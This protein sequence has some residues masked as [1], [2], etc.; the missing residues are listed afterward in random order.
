MI[1]VRLIKVCLN[2]TYDK[3]LKVH[4]GHQIPLCRPWLRRIFGHKV[5]EV[6]GG[7]RELHNEDLN[8]L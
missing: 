6:T 7:W 5:E 8:N 4:L 1:L 3:R 2:Y